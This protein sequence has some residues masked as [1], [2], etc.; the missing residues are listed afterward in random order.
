[1]KHTIPFLILVFSFSAYGEEDSKFLKFALKQ[2]HNSK[3]F[4]CDAAIRKTHEFVYGEDIRIEVSRM[5]GLASTLTMNSTFGNNNDTALI[6]AT[7][8]KKGV[9]CFFDST[10]IITSSKTCL[11][12]SKTVPQFKYVAKVGDYVWFENESGAVMQ[13]K[14]V[15]SGCVVQ[16]NSDGI[17]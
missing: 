10:T 7:Y 9:N 16:F 17:T 8:I 13:L 15:G 2:A 12:Y 14:G 6:K 4:G 5:P 11:A 1:M 3:F